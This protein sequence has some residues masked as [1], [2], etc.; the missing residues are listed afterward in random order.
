MNKI[1]EIGFFYLFKKWLWNDQ[2]K[3]EMQL[4]DVIKS[5]QMGTL[6]KSFLVGLCF[7]SDASCFKKWNVCN[8]NELR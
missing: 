2:T 1:K 8:A 7:D 4:R 3:N 5:D 6:H